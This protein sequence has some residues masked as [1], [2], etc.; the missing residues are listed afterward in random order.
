M[1][2]RELLAAVSK[3]K[4]RIRTLVAE[5]A[6]ADAKEQLQAATKGRQALQVDKI[7][8]ESSDEEVE[9]E[10]GDGEDGCQPVSGRP[11]AEAP[12]RQKRPAQV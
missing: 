1:V 11:T 12:R 2:T 9:E 5:K 10:S 3:V 8:F 6:A 4:T 7:S